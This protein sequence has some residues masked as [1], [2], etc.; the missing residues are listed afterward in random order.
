MPHIVME[1][2][3]DI[4]AFFRG[5]QSWNR[6]APGEILKLRDCY[7]SQ[8]GDT[9]LIEALCVEGGPPNRFLVQVSQQGERTTVRVYPG[10]D[11]EKTSG[12]KKI[13]AVV[14]EAIKNR[15][16]QTGYGSTNLGDYLR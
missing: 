11:P 2:P 3:V 14:A 8:S 4:E 13:L 15:N 12:L 16:P 5:F 7:L 6:Q 1:G 9:V 10:N